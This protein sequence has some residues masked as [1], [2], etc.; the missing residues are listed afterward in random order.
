MSD[1]DE[2]EISLTDVIESGG[3]LYGGYGSLP[4]EARRGLII[5]GYYD[6]M[7][8]DIA[9]HPYNLTGSPWQPYKG[10]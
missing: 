1:F 4:Y 9:L 6:M 2:R 8:D 10:L 7:Y 5:N 3:A